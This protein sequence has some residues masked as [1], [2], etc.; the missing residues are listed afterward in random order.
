LADRGMV[1]NI[2][3]LGP[4][5][6]RLNRRELEE[7]FEL[8]EMLE[9]GVA[10]CAAE[11]MRAAD[12]KAL[13]ESCARYR[14]IANAVKASGQTDNA[15]ASEMLL[16]DLTFHLGILRV[17]GNRMV[18]RIVADTHLLTRIMR[19][20]LE[21]PSTRY[22]RQLALNYSDHTRIVWALKRHD[23]PVAQRLMSGHIKRAKAFHLAVFAWDQ[24]ASKTQD[25]DLP[26][27][28]AQ[29]MADME[30]AVAQSGVK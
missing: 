28:L 30:N 26:D 7:A 27:Y 5:V 18:A 24:S 25:T 13:E 11:R 29:A 4:C 3:G 10:A 12:L 22:L 6:K 16:L 8:R 19:Q 2:S 21:L 17:G 1:K 14:E 9:S 15:N 20:C 23:G